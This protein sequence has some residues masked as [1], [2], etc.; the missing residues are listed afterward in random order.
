MESLDT[1]GRAESDRT[2]DQPHAPQAV[3]AIWLFSSSVL[4]FVFLAATHPAF[5]D[6]CDEFHTPPNDQAAWVIFGSVLL[7]S[8]MVG[9]A[10]RR[11]M[12]LAWV[13]A[14]VVVQGFV[15]WVILLPPHGNC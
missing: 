15:F 1:D 14:G 8:A 7:A 9:L 5:A 4:G 13:S 10:L 2:L 3:W 11:R 12:H 6:K